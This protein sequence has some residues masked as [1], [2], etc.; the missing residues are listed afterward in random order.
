MYVSAN[1]KAVSLNVHRYSVV[2]DNQMITSRGPGTSMEW[3]LCLVEQLYG[4]EHAKAIAAP[5][6]VQPVGLALF[7]TLFC[8][9]FTSLF[10][11]RRYFGQSETHFNSLQL[12]W[13]M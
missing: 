12:V 4:V 7:T 8:A 6:V 2:V 1:E 5:M 3:A 10:C 9:L 11:A 13:S